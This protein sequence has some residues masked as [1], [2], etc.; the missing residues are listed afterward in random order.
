MIKKW[1]LLKMRKVDL[2]MKEQEKYEA[3]KELHDHKGNK[4]RVANHLG[5]TVRHVNRLLK[6]VR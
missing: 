2:S 3:I 6:L 4:L 1:R 5:I